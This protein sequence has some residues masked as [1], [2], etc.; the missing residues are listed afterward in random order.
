MKP[1]DKLR[2]VHAPEAGIPIKEGEVYTIRRY[3]ARGG[4]A[5]GD[6][7]GSPNYD[8]PGVTLVEGEGAF[9]LK[10]FEPVAA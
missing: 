7:P 3:V 2:A 6:G 9:M 5:F 8:E 1:G 10:R 4:T